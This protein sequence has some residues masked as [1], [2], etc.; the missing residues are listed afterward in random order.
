MKKII[1]LVLA[2]MMLVSLCA[3]GGIGTTTLENG[4]DA[5]TA[6][7]TSQAGSTNLGDTISLDYV[8]MSLDAFEV[9]T[10]Y[11]FE[12]TDTSS[13]FSITHRASI[14][15][16]SDMKLICLKGKFTNKTNGDI[17]PANNP[18]YGELVVNGYTYKTEMDCYI[19]DVAES[20]FTLSPMR[21]VDYYLY[22]EV[23]VAIADAIE[24]CTLNFGFV[25]D[26]DASKPVFA[27][28]DNDKLYTLNTMPTVQ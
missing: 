3:C 28:S 1:T 23:P 2:V 5:D 16:P 26:L 24:T 19:A 4:T 11:Q 6:T 9:S 27:M 25:T 17:F 18:I 22:A 12:S 7:G 8:E 14:D 20:V 15:C 10:G 13:G 21:P